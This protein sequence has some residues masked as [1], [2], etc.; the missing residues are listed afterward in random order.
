[1]V[2]VNINAQTY[3][4]IFMLPQMLARDKRSAVINLSSRHAF[5]P[6][7][8]IPM[9]CATKRYNFALSA[10]MQEAYS[11]KL[12]V[13]TVTPASV[14]TGMNP[15]TSPYT[16]NAQQHAKAVIDQLGW[17]KRTWGSW[18]HAF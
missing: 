7:G 10:C 12:D 4:S 15:G 3:M 14:A 1:M 16:I 5:H 17:Q 13:M 9:Y 11:G 2:N 8:I 6:R 18:W